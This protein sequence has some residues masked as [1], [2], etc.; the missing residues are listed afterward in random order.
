VSE[1]SDRW[2]LQR[3]AKLRERAVAFADSLDRG[4]HLKVAGE[5]P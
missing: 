4:D 3:R 1:D 5:E 2:S